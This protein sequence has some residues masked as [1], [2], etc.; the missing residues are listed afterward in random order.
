MIGICIDMTHNISLSFRQ[1]FGTSAP[2]VNIKEV[3][4]TSDL[5][6]S[7]RKLLHVW[8]SFLCDCY[9][10]GPFPSSVTPTRIIVV[11]NHIRLSPAYV[12]HFIHNSNWLTFR[13]VVIYITIHTHYLYIENTPFTK[14]YS[15]SYLLGLVPVCFT[16][17]HKVLILSKLTYKFKYT[18]NLCKWQHAFSKSN[19][20]I[21][22]WGIILCMFKF[23]HS[24]PICIEFNIVINVT[25]TKLLFYLF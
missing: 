5:N 13:T 10:A 9:K 1:K 7:P 23:Y 20:K 17:I 22:M 24:G 12:N 18:C 6:L 14:T 3:T 16:W 25:P 2:Q 21:I 19:L 8:V 11:P 4:H 15:N